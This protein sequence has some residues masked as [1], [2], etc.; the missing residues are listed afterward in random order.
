M[1]LQHLEI[2]VKNRDDDFDTF[3]MRVHVHE[4]LFHF[5]CSKMLEEFSLNK[6]EAMTS[7]TLHSYNI[8]KISKKE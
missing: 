2:G 5:V 3:K 6:V 4:R 1:Y 8:N 7:F